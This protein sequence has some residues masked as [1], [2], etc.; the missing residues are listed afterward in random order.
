MSD[1]EATVNEEDKARDTRQKLRDEQMLCDFAAL[2]PHQKRDALFVVRNPLPLVEAGLSIA[3]DDAMSLDAWMKAG[4]FGRPTNA[5]LE[6]WEAR[7]APS[8]TCLILQPYVLVLD[9]GIDSEP[10]EE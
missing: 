8:L 6:D 3:K 5:E 1:E 2:R 4:L 7:E 9:S 10:E